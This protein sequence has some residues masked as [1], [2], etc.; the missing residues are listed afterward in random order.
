MR[1]TGGAQ[2]PQCWCQGAGSRGVGVPFTF[3]GSLNR[4]WGREC[5]ADGFYLAVF[6][7]GS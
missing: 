3:S 4:H 2:S 6:V 5:V 7:P 1:P